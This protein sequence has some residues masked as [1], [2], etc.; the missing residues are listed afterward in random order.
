MKVSAAKGVSFA[1]S[2]DVQNS[3]FT[4]R[5]RAMQSPHSGSGRSAR[6]F[7]FRLV[8]IFSE[9]LH[10]CIHNGLNFFHQSPCVNVRLFPEERAIRIVLREQ[11]LQSRNR[12][13]LPKLSESHTASPFNVRRR[14]LRTHMETGR[15]S[16]A[17]NLRTCSASCRRSVT[18]MR[19]ADTWDFRSVRGLPRG[20]PLGVMLMRLPPFLGHCRA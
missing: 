6:D 5:I 14:I 12:A 8:I 19:N 4:V 15:P 13:P 9:P 1:V 17:A 7:R 11:S 10:H 18:A 3:G 16:R 20:C 2:W